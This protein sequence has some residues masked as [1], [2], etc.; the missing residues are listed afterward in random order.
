MAAV[1]IPAFPKGAASGV[2]ANK[3]ARQAIYAV[4]SDT[5]NYDTGSS[6][7]IFSVPEE[8]VIL[9]VGLEVN[10]VFDGVDPEVVVADSNGT[11]AIFSEIP[12]LTATSVQ[13]DIYWQNVCVRYPGTATLGNPPHA[14]TLTATVDGGA[15]TGTGKIW[16]KFK[17]DAS[18][19]F[20]KDY[21]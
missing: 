20:K 9:G 19:G 11:I 18:R 2:W 7:T 10:T 21:V 13:I 15:S 16:L 12:L 8:V 14:I 4:E 17:P 1:K 6:V 3:L 5:F